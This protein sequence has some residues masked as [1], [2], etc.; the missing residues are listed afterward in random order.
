MQA[1]PDSININEL[2]LLLEG[3]EGI[4]SAKHIHVWQLDDKKIY[5]EAHL[6][7]DTTDHERVKEQ[8][9]DIIKNKFGVSHITLETK[10]V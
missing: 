10:S 4:I 9:R 1:V 3:L 7:L 2:Q 8:S 5:M 6:I